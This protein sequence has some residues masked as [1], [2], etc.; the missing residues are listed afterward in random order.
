VESRMHVLKKE[1]KIS[2]YLYEN[3][4]SVMKQYKTMLPGE[5]AKEKETVGVDK[6]YERLDKLNQ[7]L[8]I[9]IGDLSEEI[10]DVVKESFE[11][12]KS[13]LIRRYFN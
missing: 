13:D 5:L 1:E 4:F 10:G 9:Y 3:F 8:N 2:D 12:E 6:Q 7:L 11:A